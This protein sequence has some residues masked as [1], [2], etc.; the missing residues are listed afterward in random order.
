MATE[1]RK[2]LLE[3]EPAVHMQPAGHII[4]LPREAEILMSSESPEQP[5]EN[6][7]D[8]TSGPGSSQWVAQCEGPQTLVFKFDRPHH[9][10]GIVLEIE[11]RESERT[12]ELSLE[13]AFSDHETRFTEILRQEYNFSP[14]GSTFE[15]ETWVVDLPGA[16]AIRL[17]IKPHK[18]G[19]T[20]RARLNYIAFAE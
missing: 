13:A 20:A 8:G 3:S 15:R 17:N 9:V 4:N 16:T 11:E 1:L 18:G 14:A 10:R 2:K 12:Q 19:G 7:V 6:I 5:V